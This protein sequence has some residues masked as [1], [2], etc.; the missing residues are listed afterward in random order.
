MNFNDDEFTG[1]GSKLQKQ[2]QQLALEENQ[3]NLV[4]HSL[5]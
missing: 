4:C 5:V 2:I 1:H 3:V